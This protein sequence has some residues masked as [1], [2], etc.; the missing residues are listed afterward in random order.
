[1]LFVPPA[2][3]SHRH[4]QQLRRLSS[5]YQLSFRFETPECQKLLLACMGTTIL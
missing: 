2:Q 1:V 4:R 3:R 5:V